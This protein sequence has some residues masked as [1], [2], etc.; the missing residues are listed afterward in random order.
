MKEEWIVDL[1]RSVEA[2]TLP[3][4]AGARIE[5]VAADS[6]QNCGAPRCR[7][8]YKRVLAAALA[9]FLLLA[10]A[11]ILPIALRR[12]EEQEE[13]A[14]TI[15]NTAEQDVR[16]RTDYP[17]VTEGGVKVSK[18]TDEDGAVFAG[19]GSMRAPRKPE[20]VF[21]D[22]RIDIVRGIV[23]DVNY[24]MLDF[25]NSKHYLCVMTVKIDRVLHGG[26]QAGEEV[27]ISFSDDF[28]CKSPASVSDVERILD[29]HAGAEGLFAAIKHGEDSYIQSGD[30]KFDMRTISQYFVFYSEYCYTE[31]SGKLHVFPAGVFKQNFS[32]LDD[33]EAYVT[34]WYAKNKGKY[35]EIVTNIHVNYYCDG[36]HRLILSD[37]GTF[38][39]ST[40]KPGSGGYF[41]TY[42]REGNTLFFT[43]KD[44]WSEYEKYFTVPLRPDG[45]PYQTCPYEE[46]R[47][48]F[49]VIDDE[50]IVFHAAA[51][52]YSHYYLMI[53]DGEDHSFVFDP[54]HS[55]V[56]IERVVKEVETE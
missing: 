14:T 33:A 37:D 41:G 1:K 40:M 8:G 34:S 27:T 28:A 51:S 18:L 15:G 20:E 56:R 5:R 17:F 31:P 11:V 22:S 30:K 26:A 39:L 29:L 48:S 35:V 9:A 38:N 2:I 50:Q 23:T 25:G 49:E 21:T 53:D 32:S 44:N 10:T 42:K 13:P 46:V 55:F 52:N 6:G 36:N 47:L 24:L 7:W 4:E 19:A 43:L 45:E 54:V 3:K 12:G 16:V